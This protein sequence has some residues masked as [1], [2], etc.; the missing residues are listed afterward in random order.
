MLSGI[1]VL[2]LKLAEICCL[3]LLIKQSKDGHLSKKSQANVGK[4]LGRWEISRWAEVTQ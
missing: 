3:S 2:L 1:P 4:R